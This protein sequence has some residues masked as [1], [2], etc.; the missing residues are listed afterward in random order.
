[1]KVSSLTTTTSLNIIKEMKAVFARYG[2]P[3]SLVTDY[4]PQFSSKEFAVF[5]GVWVFYHITTSPT[6]PQFNGKAENAVKTIKK[7]FK[8]CQESGQS[9]YLALLNWH[10]MP[11]EGIGTSPAQCLM[12]RQCKTLL[13]MATKLLEPCYSMESDTRALAGRKQ[14]PCCTMQRI[15]G[16]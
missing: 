16:D 4:G 13:P 1:M 8:K 3:D 14:C 10:N 6:Y 11:A 15:D 12:G 9:V 5:A 7:L 2:I